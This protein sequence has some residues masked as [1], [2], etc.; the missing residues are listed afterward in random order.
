[1]D[2]LENQS[3][4]LRIAVPVFECSTNGE[5]NEVSKLEIDAFSTLGGNYMNWVGKI[6]EESPFWKDSWFTS[7][8]V[9][10]PMLELVHGSGSLRRVYDYNR[11]VRWAHRRTHLADGDLR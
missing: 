11:Y 7:A 10:P 9:A 1:M 6:I 2:S 3:V 8:L 4:S 5:Q